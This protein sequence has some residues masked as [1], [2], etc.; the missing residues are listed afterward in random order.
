MRLRKEKEICKVWQNIDNAVQWN[1]L[2]QNTK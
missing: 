2:N 1:T